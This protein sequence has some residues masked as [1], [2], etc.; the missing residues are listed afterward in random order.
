[1]REAT[2]EKKKKK[3]MINIHND[4]KFTIVAAIWQKV[5]PSIGGG[6]VHRLS[7]SEGVLS[8]GRFLVSEWRGALAKLSQHSS[9]LHLMTAG[10]YPDVLQPGLAG[11]PLSS[12]NIHALTQ[13]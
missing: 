6:D 1:M 8:G 2:E 12:A 7:Y 10:V 13:Y 3:K 9:R 4:T 11:D 5:L